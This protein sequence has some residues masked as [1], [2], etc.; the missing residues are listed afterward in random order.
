MKGHVYTASPYG[1]RICVFL[2]RK[3]ICREF[4]RM[5]GDK[6]TDQ[7]CMDGVTVTLNN[8]DGEEIILLGW[9]IPQGEKKRSL[10]ALCHEC[11]HATFQVLAFHGVKIDASNN[12]AFC[13]LMD[14]L[15]EFCEGLIK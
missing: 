12:E 8:Y 14:D 11:G 6:L 15:F 2:E 4:K 13:Y 10:S 1:T 3:D 5:T 7:K 9:F